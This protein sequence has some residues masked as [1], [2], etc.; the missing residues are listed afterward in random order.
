MT[1]YK[2]TTEKLVSNSR[3]PKNLF[4]LIHCN[5]V[6]DVKRGRMMASLRAQSNSDRNVCVSNFSHYSPITVVRHCILYGLL[7]VE[8][9]SK[10]KHLM[11]Y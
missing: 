4:R 11:N 10:S 3:L 2:T 6:Y 7:R 5:A 8:S 1:I 9:C